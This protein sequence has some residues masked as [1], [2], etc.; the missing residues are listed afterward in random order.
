[1]IT[2]T[3]VKTQ[4]ES[5]LSFDVMRDARDGKPYLVMTVHGPESPLCMR[6]GRSKVGDMKRLLE[7][8]HQEMA[9]P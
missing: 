5:Y 9:Q 1:M 6:F 7:A 4:E 8:Y 2:E 3:I